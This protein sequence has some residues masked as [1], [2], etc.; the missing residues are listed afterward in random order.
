[1]SVMMRSLQSPLT[2]ES[3]FSVV[4]TTRF[5]VTRGVLVHMSDT[6]FII[7]T[8]L[9]FKCPTPHGFPGLCLSPLVLCPVSAD[10]AVCADGF[11]PGVL[12][13]CH[14]CSGQS[15]RS[16]VTLATA[17]LICTVVAIIFLVSHLL[18]VDEY[19]SN[20]NGETALEPRPKWCKTLTTFRNTLVNILPVSAI[21]I[22]VVVLQ[23]VTQVGV[24]RYTMFNY[25]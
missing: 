2:A 3:A 1:M 10:C 11:A 22:M 4:A 20:G 16:A 19:G 14:E 9:C 7:C 13:S 8:R 18:Q 15:R 25:L 21:R 6:F 17:G 5:T 12:N 23:I 24:P